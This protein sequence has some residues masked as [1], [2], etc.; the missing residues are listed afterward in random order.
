MHFI[1]I[2]IQCS[3][4]ATM[5]TSAESINTASSGVL[6]PFLFNTFAPVLNT[7]WMYFLFKHRTAVPLPNA[8]VPHR[9]THDHLILIKSSDHPRLQSPP[10]DC[11]LLQWRVCGISISLLYTILFAC[12]GLALTTVLSLIHNLYKD[13]QITYSENLVPVDNQMGIR[14]ICAYGLQC[15]GNNSRCLA[16]SLCKLVKCADG[17]S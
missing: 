12:H 5:K 10:K 7:C 14:A 6:E 17:F 16:L 4:C 15:Q 2:G 11:L 13:L 1:W 9:L 3:E 8:P